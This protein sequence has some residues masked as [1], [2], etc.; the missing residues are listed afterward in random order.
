MIKFVKYKD[1]DKVKWDNLIS[2]SSNGFIYASSAH[3]DL[4]SNNWNALILNDYES[5]MP[6]PEKT[7]FGVRYIMQPMFSQQLGVIS[8]NEPSQF[9]INNFIDEL[10][11]HYRY[12]ALNLNFNNKICTKET[13]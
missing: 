8:K 12:F 3:L 5:V 4:V 6:L 7:K 1:I 9:C 11:N 13:I 2:Q 10:K